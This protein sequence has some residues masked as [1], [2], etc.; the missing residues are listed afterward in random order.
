[1][2]DRPMTIGLGKAGYESVCIASSQPR[3]G[4]QGAQTEN[5][6]GDVLGG[7][8]RGGQKRGFIIDSALKVLGEKG[9]RGR[10]EE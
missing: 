8:L 2:L 3:W 10:G 7:N 9:I 1:M 5:T 6:T 4:L